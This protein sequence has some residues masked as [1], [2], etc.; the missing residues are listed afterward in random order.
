VRLTFT[1]PDGGLTKTQTKW[2][3]LISCT[4]CPCRQ[5]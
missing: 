4:Q 2:L 3:L 1:D 5:I